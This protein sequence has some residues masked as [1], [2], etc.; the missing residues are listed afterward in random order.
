M[1]MYDMRT[2]MFVGEMVRWDVYRA[3]RRSKIRLQAIGQWGAL[4]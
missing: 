3:A 4:Q 2:L 1:I